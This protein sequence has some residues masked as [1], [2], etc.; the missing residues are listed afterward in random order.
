MELLNRHCAVERRGEVAWL[1][2]HEAGRANILSTAV[3]LALTEGLGLLGRE[4]GLRAIVLTGSG[5]RSFI[6]GADLRE[7]AALD[8]ASAEA[9]ITRLGGLCEAA[10]QCPLPVVARIQGWALGGGLELAMACDLRVAAPGAQFAMPE[11]KVGIPSVIHAALMPRLIGWGRA[12]WM[13]MTAATIDAATALDWGLIDAVAGPEGLDSA[14]EAALAPIL[15]CEPRAIAA[16]KALLRQWEELPLTAS[17]AA[18]VP[19]FAEAFTTDAPG[20][21]MRRALTRKG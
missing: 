12:R 4:A 5:E 15:E 14:V 9:F 11:V 8:P 3:I 1:T 6:G 2:I 19:V 7:M 10:R 20:R 21:A 13:L 16:Q 17:V 18:S